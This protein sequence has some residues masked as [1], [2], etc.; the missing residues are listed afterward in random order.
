M[1]KM[2]DSFDAVVFI[3]N[4]FLQ[5]LNYVPHYHIDNKLLALEE[6]LIAFYVVLHTLFMDV[7]PHFPAASHVTAGLESCFPLFTQALVSTS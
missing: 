7:F 1:A 6:N 4:I 3:K 2:F 5:F